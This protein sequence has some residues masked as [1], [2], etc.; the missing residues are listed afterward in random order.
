M[1]ELAVM[2]GYLDAVARK[3]DGTEEP[4]KV[5]ALPMRK[6]GAWAELCGDEPARLELVCDRPQ[7]WADELTPGSYE[8]LLAKGDAINDPIFAR[9]A[10]RQV[11]AIGQIE[12]TGRQLGELKARIAPDAP[13]PAG[14]TPRVAPRTGAAPGPATSGSCAPASARCAATPPEPQQT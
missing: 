10:E 6:I 13:A 4:V 3:R 1:D 7:G 2:L 12:R 9:W 5:L 8:E 14:A 11:R